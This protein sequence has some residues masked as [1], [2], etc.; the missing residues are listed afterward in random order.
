M[1]KYTFIFTCT[2]NGGKHQTFKVKAADMQEAIRKG[3]KTAK[4]NA[5][6]DI[7]GSWD[8]HLDYASVM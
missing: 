7:N 4:K 2:D 5:A 1:K 8:C 6:G 3:F